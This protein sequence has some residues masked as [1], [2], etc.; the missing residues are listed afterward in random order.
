M[1]QVR[2]HGHHGHGD[3]DHEHHNHSHYLRGRE[4]N[5]NLFSA[6]PGLCKDGDPKFPVGKKEYACEAEFNAAGELRASGAA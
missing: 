1:L 6:P 2:G 4:L 3:H 5:G